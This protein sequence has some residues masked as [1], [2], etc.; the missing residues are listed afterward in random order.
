MKGSL[1]LPCGGVVANQVRQPEP[2]HLLPL[3]QLGQ[4]GNSERIQKDQI[5]SYRPLSF[6]VLARSSMGQRLHDLVHHTVV[7]SLSGIKPLL[8]YCVAQIQ[9]G[10]RGCAS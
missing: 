1:V 9:V 8:R 4:F 2:T 7:G 5:R 3:M 10:G 6:L